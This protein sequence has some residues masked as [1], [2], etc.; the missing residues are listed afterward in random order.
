MI[1]L[2]LEAAYQKD[3]IVSL[4][5]PELYQREQRIDEAIDRLEDLIKINPENYFA[6]ERLLLL[7]SDKGDYDNLFARGKECATKFNMSFT[8]KIL[9]ASAALE[10]NELD[11]AE[12]E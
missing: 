10:K 5:R 3:D 4:L 9:Y 6:W 11:I 7:Y 1:I 2:V 12:E 8:A